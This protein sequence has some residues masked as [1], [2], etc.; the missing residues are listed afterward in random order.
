MAGVFQVSSDDVGL[1]ALARNIRL[2]AEQAQAWFERLDPIALQAAT[3]AA[4]NL[5]EQT[6][7]AFAEID[8][9]LDAQGCWAKQGA[10]PP[11]PLPV[12]HASRP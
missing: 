2:T 9:Q 4:S 8:R 12:R 1:V 7:L 10:L 3:V 5:E 11:P 6:G